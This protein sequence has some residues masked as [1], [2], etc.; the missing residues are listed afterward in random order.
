MSEYSNLETMM[1]TH[2]LAAGGFAPVLAESSKA[3]ITWTPVTFYVTAFLFQ[4]IG[5]YLIGKLLDVDPDHNNPVALAV[6]LG[7]ANVAAYFLRPYGVLGVLGTGATFIILLLATSAI[8]VLYAIVGFLV[9]VGIYG[10]LAI[11]LVPRT[12]LTIDGPD[13]A[14]N[15]GGIPKVVYKG[16]LEPESVKKVPGTKGD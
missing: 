5:I 1:S 12:P 3:L 7:L 13:E 16:G 10:G 14:S 8:D 6:S 9:A 11:F 2:V 15:L 4:C